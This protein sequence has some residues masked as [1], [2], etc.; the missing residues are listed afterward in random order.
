M[1]DDK[2]KDS[3]EEGKLIGL[4]ISSASIH[5]TKNETRRSMEDVVKDNTA[6]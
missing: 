2:K 3:V 1:V 6:D 4:N 5:R